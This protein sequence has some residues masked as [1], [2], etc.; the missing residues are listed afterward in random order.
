MQGLST[1]IYRILLDQNHFPAF[2]SPKNEE[3]FPGL[4]K[5]HGNCGINYK[6]DFHKI[7]KAHWKNSQHNNNHFGRSNIYICN[8]ANCRED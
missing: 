4:S 6:D 3:K 5:R 1:Q 8:M 2:S 7:T